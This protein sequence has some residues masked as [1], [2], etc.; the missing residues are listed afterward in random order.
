M[1]NPRAATKQ[2]TQKS[3]KLLKKNTSVWNI[4]LLQL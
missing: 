4:H 2:I 3:E 1:V